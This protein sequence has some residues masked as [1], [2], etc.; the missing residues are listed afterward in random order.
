MKTLGIKKQSVNQSQNKSKATPQTTRYSM[1][2]MEKYFRFQ[3]AQVS[4]HEATEQQKHIKKVKSLKNLK[5]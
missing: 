5:S 3:N 2:G 1:S 4:N